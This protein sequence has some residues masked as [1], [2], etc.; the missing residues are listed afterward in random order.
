MASVST[1]PASAS[2]PRSV[3]YGLVKELVQDES[4]EPHRVSGQAVK[5]LQLTTEDYIANVFAKTETV[6][7]KILNVESFQEARKRHDYEEE[8]CLVNSVGGQKTI[9]TYDDET[10]VLF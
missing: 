1:P 4:E 9:L 2:I 6:D 8:Q 7:N 5:L 3:F 10:D